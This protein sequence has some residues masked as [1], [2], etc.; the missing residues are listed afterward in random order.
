MRRRHG[1]RHAAAH[2][3]I[4]FWTV[5]LVLALAAGEGAARRGEL[6]AVGP[7]APG[8][9]PPLPGQPSSE[10]VPSGEPE[11]EPEPEPYA[12]AEPRAC[13]HRVP[14]D[15]DVPWQPHADL[16]RAGPGAAGP[17]EPVA[18]PL[19]REPVLDLVGSGRAAAAGGHRLDRAAPRGARPGRGGG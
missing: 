11:P 15:H 5:A 14:G 17:G 6:G 3:R 1:P 16:L 8:R 13:E 12:G 7:P 4:P 9:A 18:V 19:E 2:S 10:P